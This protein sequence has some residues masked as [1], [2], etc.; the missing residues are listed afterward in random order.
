MAISKNSGKVQTVLGLIEPEELGI[1]LPHEHLLCDGTVQGVYFI[2]P[3]NPSDRFF[4]HQLVTLENLSWVR[5]HFKDN[6]DSQVLLDEK[7]AVKEAMEFKLRGGNTIVDQTNV[8]IGRDPEALTRI[9]RATGLNII[10][11]SGYY[12]DAPHMKPMLDNKSPEEIAQEIV[13]DINVGVEGTKIHSGVIGELGCSY[14][15]KDN[16]RKSLQAGAIAQQKTGAALWVHPGR[17]EAAPIEE[18]EVLAKAGTYLSRVVIS[19]MD[20]CGFLLETRRKMLDAGCYIEYDVFGFEGYY[21][22]RVALS[23]GHLPDMPNDVGRIKEIKQLIEMGYINQILLS[24]DIGQK[25]QLVSYGGWGYAHILREVIPLMR[26]YG[27]T[28]EQIDMMMIENPK[29]LL[30]FI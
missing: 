6:L 24:Q 27:I 1:T 29:R 8:G 23:E 19:H 3:S 12:V 30:P 13:N 9:S 15:L 11:G 26:V 25:I 22:A 14:P 21:P 18:I 10:M 17:N 5:Y 7:L 16:E 20:R 28:D 2:E 4:A